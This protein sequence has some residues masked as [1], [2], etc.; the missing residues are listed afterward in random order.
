MTGSPGLGRAHF[1]VAQSQSLY[2]GNLVRVV[3]IAEVLPDGSS[4]CRLGSEMTV[5]AVAKR[6]AFFARVETGRLLYLLGPYFLVLGLLIAGLAV[7]APMNIGLVMRKFQFA[8]VWPFVLASWLLFLPLLHIE[9]RYLLPVLPAFL[10]WLVMIM[11]AL[12]KLVEPK[13][14]QRLRQFA[15][16]I[17][18]AFIAVFVLSYGYRLPTQLPQNNP[19]MFA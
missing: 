2:E 7:C 3:L 19:S 9:D 11:L 12:R 16:C 17:P 1:L 13:L 14:P 15:V 6:Y 10:V 18:L 4:V 5:S 8:D